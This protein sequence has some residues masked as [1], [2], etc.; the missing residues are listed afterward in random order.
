MPLALNVCFQSPQAR[1]ARFYPAVLSTDEF[2]PTC[3]DTLQTAS[4][5]E[6]GARGSFIYLVE[7]SAA[8]MP[9]LFHL[10]R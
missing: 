2:D 4:V 6:Q 1:A 3:V 7:C 8:C 10:H 5:S 9:A